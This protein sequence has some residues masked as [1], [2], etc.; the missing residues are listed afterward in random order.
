MKAIFNLSTRNKN[1]LSNRWLL[2]TK[3]PRHL[4]PTDLLQINPLKENISQ[5]KILKTQPAKKIFFYSHGS[6]N[7]CLSTHPKDTFN[8]FDDE[9]FKETKTQND[10]N[11]P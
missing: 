1:V 8:F 5:K 11:G 6:L 4:V 3:I 7:N 2:F 9:A 10:N